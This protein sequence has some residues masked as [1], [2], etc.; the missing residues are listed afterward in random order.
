MLKQLRRAA[1][2]YQG[3]TKVRPYGLGK[4]AVLRALEQ[5]SYIQI[6]TISVIARAHHHTLWT[7][8]PDYQ[9]D[10]LQQLIKER[11]AFEYWSHA[12]AYLPMKDFRYALPRM[13]SIKRGESRPYK[14]VDPACVRY[15]YD[16][17]RIDGPQKARDFQTA[18]KQKGQW[19]DWKPE[20]HALEK[21][22]LQGDLMISARD[23]M[24]KIY[25]LTERVLPDNIDTREPSC[26]E[27]AQYLVESH[28][29]AYGFTTIKQ[30]THLRPGTPL[31]M[32]TQ[33]VL[34][35]MLEQ[36]TIQQ[37]DIDGI[38][39]IYAARNLF[40]TTIK[41]PPATV[42][43]LSPFDNAIIHRDRTEQLFD[44]DFR[45]ECYTPQAKRRYGY[46]CLPILF[47]DKIIGRV[48]CKAHRKQRQLELVHL[49]IEDRSTDTSLLVESFVKA[50]RRFSVFNDCDTINVSKV[51]PRKLT[52]LFRRAFEA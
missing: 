21:L 10:Y 6:D 33:H 22:F 45:L 2:H 27:L 12:A 31:R 37:L 4:Q 34:Q 17:I 44:F 5:L 23:G 24:E 52:S 39:T 11:T 29:Q 19:W 38:P 28:I 8:I 3:L 48:D 30:A 36:K 50:V 35:S 51:S 46:F 40:D 42:R 25:D 9:S 16:R 41:K 49:H 47:G 43:L 7:R 26:L 32:A 13:A 15:V 14:T 20:K 1:L 18:E